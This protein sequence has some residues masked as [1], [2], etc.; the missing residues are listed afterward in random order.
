VFLGRRK[1]QRGNGIGHRDYT[2]F[3][4][5]MPIEADN[6]AP[7]PDQLFAQLNRRRSTPTTRRSNA[8]SPTRDIDTGTRGT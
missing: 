8:N 1:A 6:Q 4:R 7:L 3:A 2:L 5:T